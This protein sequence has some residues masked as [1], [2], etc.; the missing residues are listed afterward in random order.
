MY[1]SCT[2]WKN[3][4]LSEKTRP[5]FPST[6]TRHQSIIR[7]KIHRRNSTI[8]SHDTSQ[9]FH[10]SQ[11]HVSEHNRIMEC[12]VETTNKYWWTRNVPTPVVRVIFWCLMGSGKRQCSIDIRK[13]IYK[14]CSGIM[15]SCQEL[16]D[17]DCFIQ[18][19]NKVKR[20]GTVSKN[21][22]FQ[23]QMSRGLTRFQFLHAISEC[24]NRLNHRFMYSNGLGFIV[25][26]SKYRIV[27]FVFGYWYVYG[28][29]ISWI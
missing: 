2:N 23:D 25:L 27:H 1:K 24:T 5:P 3:R 6:S 19:L 14:T 12:F 28:Y 10:T 8:F 11:Q 9:H 13:S 16:S 22:R 4:I 18:H 17:G 20:N 21:K 26:Y 15:G 29:N 7:S